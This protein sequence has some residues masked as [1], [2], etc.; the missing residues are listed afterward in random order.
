MDFFQEIAS[1]LSAS[2]LIA[3]QVLAQKSSAAMNAALACLASDAQVIGHLADGE[4]L[5]I[6][7]Q[8]HLAV[9]LRQRL[10]RADRSMR[11]SS[12]GT[13]AKCSASWRSASS[14]APRIS[15][16]TGSMHSRVTTRNIQPAKASG[17]RTLLTRRYSTIS[18]S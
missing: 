3:L 12:F 2:R 6:A 8:D 10:Q 7:K 5:H 14:S 4:L 17:S 15:T 18:A 13:C 9:H 16:S 1:F 11:N